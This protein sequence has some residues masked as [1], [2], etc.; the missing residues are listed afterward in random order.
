MF[1]LPCLV[2]YPNWSRICN[3]A[4]QLICNNTSEVPVEH[5]TLK[6]GRDVTGRDATGRRT[7]DDDAGRTDVKVE[8]LM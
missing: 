3:S 6:S 4:S 5:E 7:D 8:I 1:Q 2:E